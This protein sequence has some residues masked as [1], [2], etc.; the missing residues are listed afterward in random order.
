MTINV[1]RVP[2][3]AVLAAVTLADVVHDHG[4]HLSDRVL[5]TKANEATADDTPYTS[6]SNMKAPRGVVNKTVVSSKLRLV[7]AVGLE[8]AGHHYIVGALED[9][10]ARN[11]DLVRINACPVLPPEYVADTMNYSP[12]NYANARD[13]ALRRMRK[14]AAKEEK[15]EAPGT[16]VTA[17]ETQVSIPG[18][19]KVMSYPNY[20]GK[21]KVF[22]YL[23]LAVLAQAAEAEGVDLRVVYLQRSA[24]EIMLADTSHRHFQE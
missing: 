21:D 4:H 9:M 17:Q 24:K 6:I 14:V 12:S 2:L 5:E 20:P 7:F 10:F 19:F 13:H 11:K 8:G 15:L 18:C 1:F 3:A 16:V 22:Q 23:D